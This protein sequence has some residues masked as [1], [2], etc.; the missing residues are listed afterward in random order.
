MEQKAKAVFAAANENGKQ[1]AIEI[2]KVYQKGGMEVLEITEQDFLQCQEIAKQQQA[3]HLLYF[4]DQE[5]ITMHIFSEEMG[6]L[7]VEIL[8]SDLQMP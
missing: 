3:T 4:H 6:E 7:S 8:V 1:K 2:A 5:Q